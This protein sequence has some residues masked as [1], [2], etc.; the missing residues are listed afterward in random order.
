VGISGEA[1]NTDLPSVVYIYE[2][3]LPTL[4]PQIGIQGQLT[5]KL[6]ERHGTYLPHL[7]ALSGKDIQYMDILF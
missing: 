4:W 3:E 7:P 2:S 6:K 1:L 5:N